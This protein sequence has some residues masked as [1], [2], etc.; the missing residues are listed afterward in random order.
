MLVSSAIL[1]VNFTVPKKEFKTMDECL[2]FKK[3]IEKRIDTSY[4]PVNLYQRVPTLSCIVKPAKPKAKPNKPK[5]IK[6]KPVKPI[7]YK[8]EAIKRKK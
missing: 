2:K 8:T 4:N 7:F 6:T 1:F 5:I 3:T